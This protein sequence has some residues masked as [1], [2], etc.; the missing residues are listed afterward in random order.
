MNDIR[1]ATSDDA[2]EIACLVR[3]Y[4]SFEGIE[5]FRA[6]RVEH[7]L[8]QLLSSDSLGCGWLAR[9]DGQAVAYV[10]IVYVFSLENGGL[11]AEIDELFVQ[12][13]HRGRGLGRELLAVA[14]TACREA[15]CTNISLQIGRGNHTARA[16]YLGQGFTDRQGYDLL[17]KDLP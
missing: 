10:L 2:P 7:A 8:R 4:W 15:G 13:T 5:E 17:E 9:V 12:E 1:K 14:E 3:D 11:T 6:D 16:F